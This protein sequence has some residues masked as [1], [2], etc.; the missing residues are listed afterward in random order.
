MKK[1]LLIFVILS[2]C[3]LSSCESSQI[4]NSKN[5]N[6][7]WKI[8]LYIT[9]EFLNYEEYM[10][11]KIVEEKYGKNRIVLKH[12]SENFM[13]RRDKTIKDILSFAEDEEIKAVVI[14]QALPGSIE[15]AKK[16]KK[17]RPDIFVILGTPAGKLNDITVAADLVLG[18][19]ELQIGY[20]IVDKAKDHGAK[21]FVHYSFPRHLI[22]K[23]VD[24]KR[25]IIINRSKELGIEYI[26]VITPDPIAIGGIEALSTFLKKD[27]KEKTEKYGKE[28]AFF[29]TACSSQGPLIKAVLENKA[30]YPSPCCPSPFHGFSEALGMKIGKKDL[31]HPEKIIKEVRKRI[32]SYGNS[33][34]LSTWSRPVGPMIIELGVEYIINEVIKGKNKKI[35]IKELKKHLEN[36]SKEKVRINKLEF[37]GKT[38]DNYYLISMDFIDF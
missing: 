4:L 7:D 33:G 9:S 5:E 22:D 30:I 2:F 21:F 20:E 17:K 27:V 10:A 36:Y 11:S 35:E 23:I 25:Q 32:K 24:K 8:G 1:T 38:Y 13:D 37:D 19:D 15:A 29:S 18:A 28:V 34:R 12:Y 26:D 31:S 14:V 6:E 16:L 3:F